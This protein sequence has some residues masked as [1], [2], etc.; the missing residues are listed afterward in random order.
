MDSTQG[1]KC[2]NLGQ[3]S[4]QQASM[5]ENDVKRDRGKINKDAK[6]DGMTSSNRDDVTQS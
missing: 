1:G 2:E 5:L 3:R 4:I 6:K